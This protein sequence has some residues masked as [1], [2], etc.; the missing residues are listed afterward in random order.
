MVS[1][2]VDLGLEQI[3]GGGRGSPVDAG[4]AAS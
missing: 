1:W 2:Y 3:L 4:I